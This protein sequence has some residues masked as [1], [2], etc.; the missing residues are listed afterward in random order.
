MCRGSAHE[1]SIHTPTGEQIKDP[2]HYTF[3]FKTQALQ[4]RGTHWKAHAYITLDKETGKPISWYN[5][6]LDPVRDIEGRNLVEASDE[7]YH[8]QRKRLWNIWDPDLN[9][10]KEFSEEILEGW[11]LGE[12][13]IASTVSETGKVSE[14]ERDEVEQD[15]LAGKIATEQTLAQEAVDHKRA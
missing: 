1:S 13:W 2:L 3:Q 7:Y 6:A 15:L 4:Q 5:T 8:Y 11:S 9:Q 14:K 10:I 12:N